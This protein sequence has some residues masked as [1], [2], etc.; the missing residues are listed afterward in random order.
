MTPVTNQIQSDMNKLYD[1][2]LLHTGVK[3]MRWG[4]RRKVGPNGRVAKTPK[5]ASVDHRTTQSL[6]KKPTREL[7][8]MQLKKATER[9]Q[10]ERK[11]S[12]MNPNKV[13]KGHNV[14]KGI[15]GVAGTVTAVH[16]LATSDLGKKIVSGSRSAGPPAKHLVKS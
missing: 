2:Y 12:Q 6:K 7:T 13:A 15:L 8:N 10:L 9:M 4:V 11:F 14:V 1:R 5:K 16:K 3:G